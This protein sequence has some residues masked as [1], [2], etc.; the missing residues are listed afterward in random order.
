MGQ[1]VPQKKTGAEAYKKIA[2]LLG[3]LEDNEKDLA[4]SEMEEAGF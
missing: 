4:L 3:D 2:A 1:F